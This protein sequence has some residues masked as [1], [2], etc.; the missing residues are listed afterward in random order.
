[1]DKAVIRHTGHWQR[2]YAAERLAAAEDG[3]VVTIAP[4]T[5]TLE[6]N[7]LL[8]PLL[9]DVSRQVVWHGKRLSPD[10]WKDVF[11]A[12]LRR[13]LRVVPNLDGDGFVALGQRTSTMG[14]RMFS[15]LLELIFAFGA[16]HGV[17]WSEPAKRARNEVAA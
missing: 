15:D 8:W 10:D 12:G 4:P 7:A 17:E 5:R 11:T 1:M 9:T 6:Q 3:A 14:K 13:E 16:Q 2:Q